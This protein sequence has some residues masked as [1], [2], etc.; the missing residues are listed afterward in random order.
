[1]KYFILACMIAMRLH[2]SPYL[3]P[4]RHRRYRID[5]AIATNN[6]AIIISSL[7]CQGHVV[8][9]NWSKT[10]TDHKTLVLVFT[11]KRP[12]FSVRPITSA[13]RRATKNMPAEELSSG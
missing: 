6:I 4:H 8:G 11:E 7:V 3:S 5:F 12:D 13:L 10:K 1:M 2:C 9:C